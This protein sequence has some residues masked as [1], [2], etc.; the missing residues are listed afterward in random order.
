MRLVL[1]SSSRVQDY[2]GF[3]EHA[4]PH[5]RDLF[6]GCAT[7]GFVPYAQADHA[8][9]VRMVRERFAEMGFRVLQIEN[10]SQINECEGIFIGGGNTFLLT[11]EL[12]RR[13]LI[14]P[15]RTAVLNGMPYLG[16]SAGSNVAC[17]MLSTTNDM[18][19][20]WPESF[21]TLGLV[22][23]QINAHYLD[24]DA[25]KRHNGET[26]TERIREYHE[27]NSLDVIALREGSL[28][29]VVDG[30]VQLLG[31]KPARVFRQGQE[32]SEIEP[33]SFLKL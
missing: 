11:R 25:F 12:H 18:P 2:P 6:S 22:D 19:I 20:V 24:D 27:H 23:F 10:H 21:D 4:E 32:P 33:D 13:G 30:T 31:L 8:G 3:L 5:I 26:R 17:P 9:Y 7:I 29:K 16:S 14:D 1:N 28:L 15:I